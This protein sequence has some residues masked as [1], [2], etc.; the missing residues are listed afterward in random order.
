[1]LSVNRLAVGFKELRCKGSMLGPK[2]DCGRFAFAGGVPCSGGTVSSS[3][4][5]GEESEKGAISTCSMGC[6]VIILEI[7][8]AAC[9][10][11][12]GMGVLTSVLVFSEDATDVGGDEEN[13]DRFTGAWAHIAC[14]PELSDT[15]GGVSSA[16]RTCEEEIS[17]T[18]S[19]IVNW[20]SA[21]STGGEDI[22]RR[23]DGWVEDPSA[24]SP[25]D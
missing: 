23:R 1:M 12:V 18:G 21:E 13:H 7:V 11:S 25:D 16:S 20:V 6:G 10:G 2:V 14:G 4:E 15:Y 24:S 19:T 8:P 17:G 5:G 22:S 3:E 9:C